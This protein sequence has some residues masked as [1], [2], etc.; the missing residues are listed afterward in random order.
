MYGNSH[1]R[2]TCTIASA[3][4]KLC[5][6]S[7]ILTGAF[8]LNNTSNITELVSGRVRIQNQVCVIT[9]AMFYLLYHTGKKKIKGKIN[10]NQIEQKIT[11][12][13]EKDYHCKGIKEERVVGMLRGEKKLNLTLTQKRNDQI[14]FHFQKLPVSL[15]LFKSTVILKSNSRFISTGSFFSPS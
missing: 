7:I 9:K 14:S 1:H 2:I 13:K 11:K 15:Y 4:G 12:R 10:W 5:Y 3:L 8:K 6:F